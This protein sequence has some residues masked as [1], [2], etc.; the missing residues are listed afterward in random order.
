MLRDYV[1]LVR[2][3]HRV[4]R[5]HKVGPTQLSPQ[6]RDA[7]IV[8]PAPRDEFGMVMGN[9]HEVVSFLGTMVAN[10]G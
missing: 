4:S 1:Y 9:V 5:A 3:R 10:A 2:T 7:D 6:N 8:R